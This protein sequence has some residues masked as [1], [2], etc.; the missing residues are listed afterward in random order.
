[1]NWK[2]FLDT[3]TE[4]YHIRT[5]HRES[6]L[7]RFNADCTI[8][9]G[10]GRHCLSI[11]LRADVLD[12]TRKPV[13]EWSLLPYGTIQYFLVPSGL[14]VHQLDHIERT[15]QAERAQQEE[16]GAQE[17]AISPNELQHGRSGEDRAS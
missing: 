1:M 7:P 12:E 16:A 9:D 8:Y 4:S 5:L 11:G 17:D 2:L 3:F 6:L 10:F 15:W 14:V 13:E